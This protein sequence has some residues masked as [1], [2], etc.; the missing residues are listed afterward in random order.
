MYLPYS[1]FDSKLREIER[2]YGVDFTN[3][4]EY[5][6]YTINNSIF[7]IVELENNKKYS[8]SKDELAFTMYLSYNTG[9]NSYTYYTP[10]HIFKP[11][12]YYHNRLTGFFDEPSYLVTIK[13]CNNLVA[14]AL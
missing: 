9:T 5:L 8:I 1:R 6:K 2:S 7:S 13:K 14:S 10:Y 3:V 4:R 11:K 12:T